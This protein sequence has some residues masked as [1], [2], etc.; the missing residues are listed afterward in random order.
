M[1]ASDACVYSKRM[2]NEETYRNCCLCISE[3][4]RGCMVCD[5]VIRNGTV[6]DG[7]GGPRY[8]ADVGVLDGKIAAIGDLKDVQAQKVIDAPGRFVTP[9]FIDTHSHADAENWV[10]PQMESMVGAGVTT[11]VAG[12]CGAGAAP[13]YDWMMLI[14]PDRMALENMIPLHNGGGCNPAFSR[15]VESRFVREACSRYLGTE[16]G[17]STYAEYLAAFD[18]T[19]MGVNTAFNAPH[20]QLRTSVTGMD[21]ERLLTPDEL[22]LEKDRLR[23]CFEAGAWG[24]TFGMDYKPGVW[25]PFSEMVELAK[26]AAEYDRLVVAHT[27]NYRPY[28]CGKSMPN[29]QPIEGFR[30]LLEVGLQTGARVHIS[31]I[32]LGDDSLPRDDETM[33]KNVRTTMA[34]IDEYRAKGVRATWEVL[35]VFSA[36]SVG[37]PMLAHHFLSYVVEAGGMHKFAKALESAA[38]RGMIHDEV[39]AG[40]HRCMTKMLWIGPDFSQIS[41]LYVN[42]RTIE[43]WG[44]AMG[45]DALYAAL[46]LLRQDPEVKALP[47]LEKV[48]HDQLMEEYLFS[49]REEACIGFDTGMANY[50]MRQTYGTDLPYQSCGT[51]EFGYTASFIER[52]IASPERYIQMMCGNGARTMGIADRGFIKE[53][54]YADLLVLDWDHIHANFS[55]E[56]P[57]QAPDGF[58]Y[59][60]V[61]GQISVD[62]KKQLHPMNGKVLRYSEAYEPVDY[63]MLGVA[64]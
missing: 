45:V 12:N 15:T 16:L 18:R 10:Y 48:P 40:N 58:D 32:R 46:E 39:S 59:V 26:V 51:Y 9:G 3:K 7:S 36:D 6:L 20:S 25:T 63:D 64:R 54:C 44:R 56:N 41:S 60:I 38:Y 14:G 52:K 43:D 11:C 37:F 4:G 55:H 17:W 21:W 24:L 35:P 47:P 8:Q 28:R 13:I 62:H 2:H 22:E 42:G 53:G 19:G 1:H 33:K 31:H 23:E 57:A 29:H 50:D 34:L 49:R 27:H 61:N 30:E 5:L